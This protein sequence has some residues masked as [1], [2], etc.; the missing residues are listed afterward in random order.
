M[1]YYV[2]LV[3]GGQDY[4]LTPCVVIR[5]K[6]EETAMSELKAS[7]KAAY[8]RYRIALER[9][10]IDELPSFADEGAHLAASSEDIACAF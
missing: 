6:D 9:V 4:F 1:K 7:N 2:V 10:T 3:T 8:M 5:A